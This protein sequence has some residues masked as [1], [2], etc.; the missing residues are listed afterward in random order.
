MTTETTNE[1]KKELFPA[2]LA[3]SPEYQKW[4]EEWR[5]AI[6]DIFEE[7]ENKEKNIYLYQNKNLRNLEKNETNPDEKSGPKIIKVLTDYYRNLGLDEK[8]IL[9]I[10]DA[11]V[12]LVQNGLIHGDQE[13]P[14]L[15]NIYEKREINK[16]TNENTPY[17]YIEVINKI[18]NETEE[19][20]E[21]IEK[22]K[23]KLNK[24]NELSID[25]LKKEYK[26]EMAKWWVSEK[27]TGNLGFRQI[28]RKIKISDNERPLTYE[29]LDEKID[30][31][32]ISRCK[33]T[34]KINASKTNIP[35]KI[36]IKQTRS[37]TPEVQITDTPAA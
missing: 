14:V 35:E 1:W 9:R 13:Y 29:Q 30:D 22:F 15:V 5:K 27:W 8:Y 18:N 16:E 23:E 3:D 33:V 34:C 6:A 2:D 17:I 28:G 37:A 26:Q 24:A 36:W 31:K 20:K 32:T 4:A 10:Y 21:A 25:E 19:E 7:K 12:E 11:A